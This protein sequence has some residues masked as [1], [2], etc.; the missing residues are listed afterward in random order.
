[1]SLPTTARAGVPPDAIQVE[2]PGLGSWMGQVGW[3]EGTHPCPPWSPFIQ[4]DPQRCLSRPPGAGENGEVQIQA[5]GF[6]GSRNAE[7]SGHSWEGAAGRVP[8]ALSGRRGPCHGPRRGAAASGSAHRWTPFRGLGRAALGSDSTA[9]SAPPA[10]HRGRRGQV[11]LGRHRRS[12]GGCRDLSH[13]YFK[14]ETQ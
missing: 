7:L 13:A 4:A 10:L 11:W 1:M 3:F 12:L 8:A 6:S 14:A 5:A 2:L 9:G